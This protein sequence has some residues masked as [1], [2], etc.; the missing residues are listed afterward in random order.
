M[1][2]SVKEVLTQDI[3]LDRVKNFLEMEIEI[4]R[5]KELLATEI[6]LKEFLL[7][8][9]DVKNLLPKTKE[10]DEANSQT[11][12][13][14]HSDFSPS[15]LKGAVA[16]YDDELISALQKDHKELLFIYNEIIKNAKAGKYSLVSVHLETFQT[17]L[18][19]H[20]HR[21]DEH[22]YKYLEAFIAEKYPKRKKAFE[23]LNKE[24]KKISIGIFYSLSESIDISLC[25][26]TFYCF[27]CVFTK[28]GKQLNK[29]I[30]REET[31]LLTMYEESQTVN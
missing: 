18:T 2:D 25:D 7:Q 29:R 9:I 21:A 17:L 6:K 12:E 4:K 16:I 5:L 14:T 28:L 20:Y 3:E 24:M 23:S 13:E 11:N 10:S 8:E 15:S 19:K 27:M 31:L 30:N 1:L 22:L 26:D